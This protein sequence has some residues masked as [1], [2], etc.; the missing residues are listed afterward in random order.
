MPSPTSLKA[1]WHHGISFWANLVSFS[2]LLIS[3]STISLWPNPP[4]GLKSDLPLPLYFS[5][6]NMQVDLDSV[7][8]ERGLR[9]C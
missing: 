6:F 8:Q 7:G 3:S 5:K 1:P 4:T 2:Y 9:V